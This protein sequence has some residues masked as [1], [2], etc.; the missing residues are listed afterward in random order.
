[1]DIATPIL[2]VDDDPIFL[3]VT[4]EIV[5]SLG[6]HQIECVDSAIRG[7][8]RIRQGVPFGLILLDLNMPGLDGL[9]FLRQASELGFRGAVIISSGEADAV[10]R[11]AG[12]MGRLLQL[13]VLGVLRKPVSGEK[14]AFLLSQSTEQA[15]LAIRSTAL[16][17]SLDDLELVPYYQAQ[18]DTWNGDVVGLEALIR[19]R[20][21]DG[22][23]YGP[24]KLFGLIQERDQLLSTTLAIAEVVMGDMQHWRARGCLRRTSINLDTSVVED[25]DAV[26]KLISL[27]SQA[28]LDPKVVCWE[29]TETTLPQDVTRVIEGLSRLRMSGCQVSLDDYGTGGSNFEIL[30]L[31]PFTELKIDGP[32]L[33]MATDD[34]VTQGFVTS[35]L[36]M[37]RDLELDVVGEGVETDTQYQYARQVGIPVIQGYWF[38]KP[39]PRAEIENL[40]WE[41]C[42]V[43][44]AV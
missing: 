33:R 11:S 12:Q 40:L 31:C 44:A 15:D 25:C 27:V 8:Q 38:S 17:S 41:K 20:G 22:R 21:R 36:S 29:V 16:P 2:I 37:A 28:R 26:D 35:T 24:G 13:R 30:R 43:S 42:N 14:L 4:E 19:G 7:L 10:L 32:L 23:I 9:A 18:H 5:A 6:Y 3:A 1:M 39:L 34:P